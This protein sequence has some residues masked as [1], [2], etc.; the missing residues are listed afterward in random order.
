[1]KSLYAADR[2]VINQE[3]WFKSLVTLAQ[4]P[5]AIGVAAAAEAAGDGREGKEA[6]AALED[7][8]GLGE[9]MAEAE[10]WAEGE[11]ASSAACSAAAAAAAATIAEVGVEE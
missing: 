7:G 4:H 2:V 6:A 8:M 3:A 10:P 11:A 9:G 1:M 5:G